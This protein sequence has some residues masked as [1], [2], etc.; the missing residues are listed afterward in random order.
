MERGGGIQAG[1]ICVPEIHLGVIPGG[2]LCAL[3]WTEIEGQVLGNYSNSSNVWRGI[4]KTSGIG[5]NEGAAVCTHLDG[6]F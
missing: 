3:G 1:R 5:G 6:I 4:K 2:L